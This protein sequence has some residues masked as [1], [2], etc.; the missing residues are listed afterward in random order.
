MNLFGARGA[1]FASAGGPLCSVL[2]QCA[3]GRDLCAGPDA[4]AAV[5]SIPTS[6]TT[7]PYCPVTL[8]RPFAALFAALTVASAAPYCRVT[9]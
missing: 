7:A 9:G 2:W 3:G 5:G 6:P 8:F 1:G 4:L